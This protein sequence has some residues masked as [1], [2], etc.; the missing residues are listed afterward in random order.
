MELEGRPDLLYSEICARYPK[1]SV[2]RPTRLYDTVKRIVV[3]TR[4]SLRGAAKLSGSPLAAYRKRVWKP[5]IRTQ[6]IYSKLRYCI[7]LNFL[8]PAT[9][10]SPTF[11]EELLEQ[12]LSEDVITLTLSEVQAEDT[13]YS[14]QL[15]AIPSIGFYRALHAYLKKQPG[16]SKVLI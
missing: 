12:G 3:P 10:S 5:R 16:I 13:S 14:G 2:S 1:I 6:G 15:N 7:V 11:P 4:P 9:S 8:Y